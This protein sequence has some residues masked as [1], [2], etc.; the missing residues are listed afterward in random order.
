M[1]HGGRGAVSLAQATELVVIASTGHCVSGSLRQRLIAS[2]EPGG[3]G[4]RVRRGP[5]GER[6]TSLALARR[7]CER[8]RG[9][10]TV[11][12]PRGGAGHRAG[13]SATSRTRWRKERHDEDRKSVV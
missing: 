4:V 6:E 7:V 3:G 1:V 12:R 10:I 11:P 5:G 13:R 2:A 9:G 8:H